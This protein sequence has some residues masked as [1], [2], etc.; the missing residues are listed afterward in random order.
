M[1]GPLVSV[2]IPVYLVEQYLARCVDSVIAQDYR[3]IEI[4]LVNDGSPDGCGDII[5]WY[6]AENPVVRSIWQANSGLAAARNAGIASAQG[7]YV[8]LVDSDDFVEPDLVSA[9]VGIAEQT[10]ADAVVCSFY[11]ELPWGARVAVP[12]LVRNG[13]ITGDRAA[14]LS[15]RQRIPTFAWNKLY[16]RD[17]FTA[18]GVQFSPGYYEDVATCPRAL[19]QAGTVAVTRRPYYHYCP[20]RSG[21][22][23]SF[24]VR[25]VTDYLAAIDVVRR[26]M[27]EEGLWA[28]WRGDY[29]RLLLVAQAQL[30]VQVWLQPNSLRWADR[31]HLTRHLRQRIRE[32][33]LPPTV[34]PAGMGDAPPLPDR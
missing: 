3:P 33:R 1:P 26:F 24:G 6:E 8:A 30:L 31:N 27:V 21:I 17:L 28:A 4:I 5:R 18:R 15:L 7:E 11:V 32:L 29:R 34:D 2:V 13:V 23:G 10:S 19:K 25:N 16:R 14:R 9:L 20:R 12:L 22:T